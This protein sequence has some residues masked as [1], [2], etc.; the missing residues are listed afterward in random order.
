MFE[1]V[2]ASAPL[3]LGPSAATSALSSSILPFLLELLY[4]FSWLLDR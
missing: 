4:L 2:G 1:V 3:V